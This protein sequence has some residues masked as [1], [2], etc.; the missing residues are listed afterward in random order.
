MVLKSRC[1]MRVRNVASFRPPYAVHVDPHPNVL[2]LNQD[3][4][5]VSIAVHILDAEV[6]VGE[7]YEIRRARH[8]NLAVRRGC[9]GQAIACSTGSP[10]TIP[11]ARPIADVVD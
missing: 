5:I 1:G 11:T 6:G 4:I 10:S 8:R 3:Q 2:K 9:S 7:S